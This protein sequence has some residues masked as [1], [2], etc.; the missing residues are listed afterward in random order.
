MIPQALRVVYVSGQ[1]GLVARDVF[2]V[3]SVEEVERAAAVDHRDAPHF[4]PRIDKVVRH[5]GF[6]PMPWWDESTGR[7]VAKAVL[8]HDRTVSI[9][10]PMVAVAYCTLRLATFVYIRSH[11]HRSSTHGDLLDLAQ[12]TLKLDRSAV[13]VGA[14]LL[15]ASGDSVGGWLVRVAGDWAGGKLVGSRWAVDVAEQ[16]LAFYVGNT[17]RIDILNNEGRPRGIND[18]YRTTGVAWL[19]S[20]AELVIDRDVRIASAP[21]GLREPVVVID[22]PIRY[23]ADEAVRTRVYERRRA[24]RSV[25]RY[26]HTLL[27]F[28][29][30]ESD[31]DPARLLA[32]VR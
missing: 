8:K 21:V 6:E 31:S 15:A 24:D 3:S 27:G 25:E 11:V 4:H 9:V 12:K 23:V 7:T 13:F 29:L 22:T 2:D 19:N 5:F 17:T 1:H 20:T 28:D 32:H 10:E 26:R 18:L 14:D 30:D 16:L